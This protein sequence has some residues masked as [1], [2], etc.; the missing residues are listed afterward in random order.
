MK[1]AANRIQDLLLSADL[2]K[3]NG[4]ELRLGSPFCFFNSDSDIFYF[5]VLRGNKIVYLLRV[6]PLSS[7][8]YSCVLSEMLTQE[9]EELAWRTSE[10]QPL[11]LVMEQNVIAAYIGSERYVLFAYPKEGLF[12]SAA[13]DP[14]DEFSSYTNTRAVNIKAT[15]GELSFT[16]PVESLLQLRAHSIA[17][18]LEESTVKAKYLSTTITETQDTLPWCAAYA[19]AMIVRYLIGNG[20]NTRDIMSYYY[21]FPNETHSLS[22]DDLSFYARFRGIS[23]TLFNDTIS[24]SKLMT[25]IDS[26]RPVYLSMVQSAINEDGEV[27]KLYHA[28]VLRGYDSAARVWSI[29][30]PWYNFYDSFDMDGTYVPAMHKTVEYTYARTIYEWIKQ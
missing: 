8:G 3:L 5:P 29:W 12:Y 19:T 9:L 23:V 6:Y 17:D 15:L 30:N 27:E 14:Q 25:E 7:G 11:K 24:N 2:E 13:D 4:G 1:Y 26:N 28:V 10:T 20:D 18:E 21:G 16:I 22:W